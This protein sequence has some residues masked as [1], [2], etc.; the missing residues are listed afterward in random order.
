LGLP[1]DLNPSRRWYY[2]IPA[3]GEPIAL[4]HRIEPTSLD[5][6]P[7]L[8]R[9]YSQWKEQFEQLQFML[10]GS[11]RV[12]MQYSP[13]CAIPYVSMVDCGTIELVRTCGVEVLSSAN[14][15][16]YFEARWTVEQMQSHREAGELIDRVRADAFA[17]ISQKVKATETVTEFEVA[18]FIRESFKQLGLY[19]DHGPIVAVNA[20]ASNP[21]YQPS[22]EKAPPIR[23][24]DLV[25]IDLWAKLDHPNSVYYDIT[26][27]GYCG[28]N[29]P[30][31]IE[32]VFHCVTGARDAAVTF[33]QN[34]WR[35]KRKVKGFEVDDVAREYVTKAGYGPHFFHRTG[36]S[37]GVDVHGAGANIDNF[38]THDERDIVPQTCFSI[39]PGIY[40]PNF[41][42]R[43][44]VN[45]FIGDAPI[46]TGEM[47]TSLLRLM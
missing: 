34:A 5:T 1:V 19:A 15:V 44:E 46:V 9:S 8:K 42:I 35:T 2:F 3:I 38:E 31:E 45:V 6:L 16:Q 14:F 13:N 28:S 18:E 47:Q 22:R 17:L 24:G 36:H 40:L 4:V 29:P 32:N 25:L 41:G 12:V 21:H 26:W 37:I 33:V 10:S 30:S 27:T 11:N 43:S 39:E 23:P 7:G 20:N